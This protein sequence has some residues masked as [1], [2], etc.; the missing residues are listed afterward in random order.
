[1]AQKL[2]FCLNGGLLQVEGASPNTTLLEFLRSR[3]LTGVKEGCA[4]GDCGACSV[5]LVERD[6]EGKAAY[7]AVNSCL[8]PIALAAS[9]EIITVEGV[10]S[11]DRMHPVQT[12]LVEHRGSQCGYCT[13]G[14]VSSLFEAYY[15]N[16]AR[17]ET[18]VEEQLAGNLCRCTGYSTICKAASQA[19]ASRGLNGSGDAFAQRLKETVPRLQSL[20]YAQGTESFARPESLRELFDILQANPKACLIAGATELALD[21]TKRFKRFGSM[22][23]VEAVPELTEI[24]C[25]A[26]EWHIGA[27]ATLTDIESTVAREYP[28]LR[29]M[30]RVFGSRQIRNR[31][32]MGGN[33]VTAS[34]IGDSAPVLLSLDATLI[35]AS[36]RGE[37]VVPVTEFFRSYRQTALGPGEILKT[38]IVPRGPSA[39]GL[40]RISAWYK[41]SRRREMDI[42]TV[43]ACFTVDL[44]REGIVR[45]ARLA[46]GGVATIPARARKTEAALT[47]Q[48]WSEETVRSTLTLLRSEFSPI[49]DV[50]GS[51]AYRSAL[52]GSLLERF[53][54]EASEGGA[55]PVDGLGKHPTSNILHPTSNEAQPPHESAHKHV[56]GEAMY[57]DDVAARRSMLEIWL[58]CAPHARAR[59]RRRDASAARQM[60]GIAAVLLAE[61]LPG[62]NDAGAVRHDEPLLAD[63]EVSYHSQPVALVVGETQEACRAAAEKVEVEYEPLPPLL[64]IE[65]AVAQGSFHTDANYLRRGNV[66]AMLRQAPEI[67]QGEF[68]IGGQEHFY[69]EMQAAWAEPGE[70]GSVFVM[71]STQHPSEVQNVVARVLGIGGNRV[72]VESPRMGGGFGGKETQAAAFAA[73]AALAAAKTGRAVRV[74]IG[75]DS[76]MMLTGKRHPFLARFNVGYNSAGDLLA[77]QIELFSN[78]GWSLDLSQ[79]V[80]DRALFHLDN[81][82]YIPHVEFSGRVVKTNLASNTAFRGFGGPQGMLVIEEIID[83][84]ARRLELPPE[85]VRERNLYHGVGETNTTPYGQEIEDNRIQRVWRELK[86]GSNFELRRREVEAWNAGHPH[87]KRGL[88]I[89]PVKFG[90]SFTMTHLN[91][92]GALVLIFQ[93]GT[94]QVNQGGTEMGQGVCTNIAMV[95]ARELGLSLDRIRVMPTCT[96]KVPNTSATAASCGTD[97]NGMA[98]KAACEILRQRLAKVAADLWTEKLGRS[99]QAEQVRF[100]DG[101][102]VFQQDTERRSEPGQ[103]IARLAFTELVNAAYI[104]RVSLSSTGYYRT[105]EI[106]YD[107]E[108][109]RG[110]PFLYYAVGAA[111]TEVELDG[112]TGMSLV[113]RTDILQDVGDSINAGINLGQIEGGFVQGA[114]WL[115]CEEL[116]W[117]GQGRLL[118]HSPDT[119]KIPAVGDRPRE[120][121]VQLLSQAAQRQTIF[122]SKAVG[123][124]PFMLAI[125][126]REAIRDAVAAFGPPGGE[127][128]LP[129]PATCE[130]IYMAIHQRLAAGS[131]SSRAQCQPESVCMVAD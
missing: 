14:I 17:T 73:L 104:Q 128:L 121:N 61:D 10:G 89:T 28:A 37:R 107:R 7:R 85:Q 93:D 48:P 26:S 102:A 53:F 64:G 118:T 95:A 6:A 51:A 83:R 130:V 50:R 31:A 30:L 19:L 72:V 101:F 5:V 24:R 42:S 109:G 78:G 81:A 74:R 12:S 97:L 90:I 110:R 41:V 84:I 113:L 38:I 129:T 13:P 112:F 55:E 69:L 71:S 82:Y 76:D 8:M 98:V 58:V 120:F 34:P 122:G 80:T 70:D 96:D 23:S 32:T 66:P 46:Y 127:V 29:D 67:L 54:H 40:Q 106:H 123:E 39:P 91:Q 11:S 117:D 94:V 3:G 59:I 65:E 47:G 88:A 45:H 36:P 75:R 21:I 115:T 131:A 99:V 63:D 43:A 20:R 60:P 44:D 116:V 22:V 124:P 9:R 33:L 4:E 92:A 79:A 57:T 25:T 108:K 16:D 56:T 68:R 126:V 15:R 119:Y 114:G 1:M 18:E 111:V 125:S 52:I 87:R 77:A 27:A 35:L 105:P 49:S 2:E 86:A 100:E 103:P 62:E